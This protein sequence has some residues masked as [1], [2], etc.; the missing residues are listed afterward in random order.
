MLNTKQFYIG[1]MNIFVMIMK[2][3]CQ[4]KGDIGI[5]MF[6]TRHERPLI[7]KIHSANVMQTL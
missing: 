6:Y 5:V 7:T 4:Q 1:S 2:A 3:M